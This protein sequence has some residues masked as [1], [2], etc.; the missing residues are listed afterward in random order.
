MTIEVPT[1]ES[2]ADLKIAGDFFWGK[3]QIALAINGKIK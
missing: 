2:L 3:N 1:T